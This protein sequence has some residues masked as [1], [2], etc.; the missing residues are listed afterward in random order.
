MSNRCI[1]CKTRIGLLSFECS[2]CNC[3]F[4]AHHRLPEDHN[5]INIDAA[6]NKY[7]EMNKRKLE[8]ESVKE[9]KIV[10]F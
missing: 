7:K 10:G 4:C 9:V 1:Q 3:K 8:D 5:C 2:F 6:K